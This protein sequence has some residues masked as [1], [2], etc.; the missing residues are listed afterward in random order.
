MKKQAVL[1]VL[2]LVLLNFSVVAGLRGLPLLAS[3]GLSSIFF[4]ALAAIAF[5]IPI[6]LVCAELATGWPKAGGVYGW[7]KE[8]FGER[9]GFMAVWLQW[10]PNLIWYPVAISF[11]A[12]IFTNAFLGGGDHNPIYLSLTIILIYW[13]ATLVNLRGTGTAN[14]IIGMLILIGTMIPVLLLVLSSL[15]WIATGNQ[16]NTPLDLGALLPAFAGIGSIALAISVFSSYSG[17]EVFAVRAGELKNPGTDYPKAVLYSAILVFLFFSLGTLAIAVLV[18][19]GQINLMTGI[20][21]AFENF[22]AKFGLGKLV[23]LAAILMCLGL[24]GQ[25][26]SWIGGPS[27][28]LLLA[29]KDGNLPPFFSK[30]NKNGVQQNILLVQ[31]SLVTLLAFSFLLAPSIE[32]VYWFLTDLY[33]HL[34]LIMYLVLFA[35]VVKLRYAKPKIKRAFT[36]PF[37]RGGVW[38]VAGIGFLGVLA[39]FIVGL[40]PPTQFGEKAVL[41]EIA[42]LVSIIVITAAPF[43]IRKIM[44]R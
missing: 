6:S 23:P 10:A 36:I 42:S 5:L 17:M 43:L 29:A 40:I 33:T 12:A 13:L 7:A 37:G 24:L 8:A 27:R 35:A 4:Y 34:Y 16:T 21:D 22:S 32:A 15:G 25:V 39:G 19:H 28:G 2:M 38:L 3:Y 20:I 9:I 31:G 11:L 30:L 44:K 41:F 26:V 14:K 1:T 18:P